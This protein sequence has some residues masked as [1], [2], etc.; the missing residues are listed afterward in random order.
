[1]VIGL[2]GCVVGGGEQHFEVHD[3]DEVAVLATHGSVRVDSAPRQ[4][5]AVHWEGGGVGDGALLATEV[6]DG[7]LQLRSDCDV[8][9]GAEIGLEVPEGMPVF[10]QLDAGEALISL[11]APADVCAT[12]GAGELALTVPAGAYDLDLDVGAG[13]LSVR[14]VTDDPMARHGITATVATGELSLTGN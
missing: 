8:T 13:E 4:G 9:C 12:T 1:M 14:D 3:V 2:L 6:V 11:D 10:V 5:V 7:V